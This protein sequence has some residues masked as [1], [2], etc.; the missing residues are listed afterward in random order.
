MT[1]TTRYTGL[2][3]GNTAADLLDAEVKKLRAE[4][5]RLTAER[6]A[7]SHNAQH[8][9]ALCLKAETERDVLREA[10]CGLLAHSGIADAGADMKDPED[11]AAESK[12]RDALN[13]EAK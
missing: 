11:H 13:P 8:Y 10:V 9:A 1:D 4:V 7:A 5:A 2:R 6:D 3:E 12:A